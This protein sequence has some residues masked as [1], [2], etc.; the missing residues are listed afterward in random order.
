MFS[1]ALTIVAPSFL[2]EGIRGYDL[3]EREPDCRKST[4]KPKYAKASFKFE[5]QRLGRLI[6]GSVTYSSVRT[7][8]SSPSP[9]GSHGM[10][11]FV[12][13][14]KKQRTGVR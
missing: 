8:R 6:V 3:Q 13:I 2:T 7:I 10:L 1:Q 11:Q 12:A 5:N 4:G 9:R 14:E